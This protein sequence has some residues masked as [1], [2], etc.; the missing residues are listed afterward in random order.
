LQ[1]IIPAYK[2]EGRIKEIFEEEFSKML[3]EGIVI[4]SPLS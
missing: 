1:F 2:V 3:L 4:T